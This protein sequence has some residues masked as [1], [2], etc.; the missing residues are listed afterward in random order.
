ML[1]ESLKLERAQDCYQYQ[2]LGVQSQY[3]KNNVAEKLLEGTG[4][5]FLL[6]LLH[7]DALELQLDCNLSLN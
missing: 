5:C 1:E 7:H 6:E 3:S 4:C 2:N